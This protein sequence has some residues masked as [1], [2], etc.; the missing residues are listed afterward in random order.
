MHADIVAS[1]GEQSRWGHLPGGMGMAED[2][3]A[4]QRRW[5]LEG[6]PHSRPALSPQGER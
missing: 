6:G 1:L 5:Q 3:P 4:S 2:S